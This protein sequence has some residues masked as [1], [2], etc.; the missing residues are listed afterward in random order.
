MVTC[1][2]LHETLV[3]TL[4]ESNLSWTFSYLM[5]YMLTV[6]F[7]LFFGIAL[8]QLIDV[9][10]TYKKLIFLGTFLGLCGIGFA[11]HP[12]FEGDLSNNVEEIPLFSTNEIIPQGMSMIALPGCKFCYEQIPTLKKIHA[13]NPKMAITVLLVLPDSLAMS[14]YQEQ[15]GETI[16]VTSASNPQLLSDLV[17][18]KYPTYVYF[19]PKQ[20]KFFKWSMEGLG[21][22]GLDFLEGLD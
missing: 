19:Q 6:T 2:L 7:I 9:G 20:Q 12:I 21:A 5:P 17:G 16:R 4:V 10:R 13:R 3:D 15:L 8:I 11:V 22:V 18:G 14:D 1:I